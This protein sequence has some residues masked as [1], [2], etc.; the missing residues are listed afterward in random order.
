M[1][2]R[3]SLRDL[4][5][6]PGQ[7][8]HDEVVVTVPPY[9]QGGFD[10]RTP[11]GG[12]MPAQLDITAMTRGLDFRL[13]FETQLHGPCS[14]CL[15]EA[16]VPISVD[17]HEVDDPDADD[18]DLVS[19]FVSDEGHLDIGAWAHEEVALGFPIVVLCRDDCK[20][21]C[22]QCGA[23]HNVAPCECT[24]VVGDSRWDKLRELQVD[25]LSAEE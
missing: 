12:E 24:V 11:D 22:A 10:Y 15:E 14:R 25:E 1:G 18:P 4:G 7:A 2:T 9:R 3:Y 6:S 13:R 20:G 21:L 17:S 23:N 16:V 5:L 8:K 19:D